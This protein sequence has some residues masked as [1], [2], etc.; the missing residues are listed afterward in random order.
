M[1]RIVYGKTE[2]VESIDSNGSFIKRSKKYID[3]APVYP[4]ESYYEI[5][6]KVTTPL[7]AALTIAGLIKDVEEDSS[8][9][10]AGYRIEGYQNKAK[11]GYYYIV[12]CFRSKVFEDKP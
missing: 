12:K 3:S 9:V 4:Q 5:R 7:E 10:E 11:N 8:I 6:D 2:T 1:D